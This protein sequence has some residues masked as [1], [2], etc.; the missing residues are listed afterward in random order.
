MACVARV[1]E[2]ALPYGSVGVGVGVGSLYRLITGHT[3]QTRWGGID[4][5]RRWISAFPTE[6]SSFVMTVL[7][8][9]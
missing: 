9:C 3:G 4:Q 1:F 7:S 6:D 2:Q 5:V 8:D